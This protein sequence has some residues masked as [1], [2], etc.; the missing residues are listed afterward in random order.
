M[1]KDNFNFFIPLEVEKG[2]T[3]SNDS[4]RYKNMF[5]SG[6]AST[7]DVDSDEEILEPSGFDLSVFR[8]KGTINY[9]H[10]SKHS[11]LNIVG[12][13]VLAEIK[14]NK[15]FIKGKLWEKSPKARDLWDTLQI[16][17]ESGSTRKL[18]WSIEG[19]PTMKDPHNPKRIMKA[20]ITNIA[21]TFMPKNPSTF[22]EICKG[23]GSEKEL[24]YDIPTDVPYLYKG[25]FGDNEY[26][27][28]KDFTITKA[29]G[30]GS[31]GGKVIGHTKSGKP[32]YDN[33]KPSEYKDFSGIDHSDA[34]NLHH[35]EK[36][37][38]N[39][40]SETGQHHQSMAS[41]H[42][43]ETRKTVKLLSQNL[44]KAFDEGI[45]SK[46]VFEKAMSAGS[47][48]GQQ[49]VGQNTSGAALK[50]ESLDT[51]LKIL[52]IP[53]EGIHWAA[54]NWDSFKEDTKRALQ[55][56]MKNI[57]EKG[58]EGSRGGHII[59]RTKS[60]KSIYAPKVTDPWNKL[61]QRAAIDQKYH[62]DFTTEDRKDAI[63][64]H[65]TKYD[66]HKKEL[67]ELMKRPDHADIPMVPVHQR[68]M[69][70]HQDMIEVHK[71][72]SK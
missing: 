13:P 33:K 8:T 55:K 7:A 40:N 39:M 69:K 38:W 28:H 67:D 17:Q 70:E 54:D 26:T 16:M 3:N 12:E 22:A 29:V 1:Y 18:G 11:P 50:S 21:L 72:Q 51:D 19:K 49:L 25:V 68:K 57:L 42:W 53:I 35:T 52:T 2:T 56:G 48:T 27:L 44:H 14:D 66:E 24:D 63:T 34:G 59:G 20:L 36:L 45:I 64:I 47:E 62:K 61:D 65:Q 43:A 15:F 10:L 46:E 9:E 37:K 31:R 41:D 4:N 6:V 23:L 32:V 58:G 5:L 60:G 30:E 71:R